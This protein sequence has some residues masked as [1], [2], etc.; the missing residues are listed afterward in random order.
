MRVILKPG[1][2]FFIVAAVG[3]LSLL[4]FLRPKSDAK[5]KSVSTRS[6]PAKPKTSDKAAYFVGNMESFVSVTVPPANS[7]A[8]ITGDIATGFLDNSNWAKLTVA[9]SKDVAKPHTGKSAQKIAVGEIQIGQVQ[10]NKEFSLPQ[11]SKV[12]AVVWLRS[13]TPLN[14]GDVHLALRA[15]DIVDKWHAQ[16]DLTL[17]TGWQKY[18]VSGTVEASSDTYLM[19]VVRKQNVAVYVDDVTVTRLP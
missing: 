12:K 5:A 8:K 19:L 13:D 7:K 10:F 1:G 3:L 17:G 14:K 4:I 15:K 2:I 9:Y 16:S 6:T 18:E 11:G